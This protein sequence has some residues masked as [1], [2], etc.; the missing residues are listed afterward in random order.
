MTSD[1]PRPPDQEQEMDCDS[2][3][4]WHQFRDGESMCICGE[5]EFASSRPASVS[6]QVE[7]IE[8]SCGCKAVGGPTPLP[9]DCPEHGTSLFSLARMESLGRSGLTISVCCGPS[10]DEPFR[11]TVQ[12]LSRTGQTFKEP[13]AANDFAHAIAIAEQEIR[14]RGW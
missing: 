12:V 7:A 5:T 9:K 10:G 11:W 8:Y 1:P 4:R 3:S 13:Y 6:P 14:E 2:D